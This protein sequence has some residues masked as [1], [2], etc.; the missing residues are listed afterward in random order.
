MD[1][2]TMGTVRE[3]KIRQ[4][5]TLMLGYIHLLDTKGQ[6]ELF[7]LWEEFSDALP[8]FATWV[9]RSLN[10]SLLREALANK[11]KVGIWHGETSA[12]VSGVSLLAP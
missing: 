12:N 1:V 2:E 4:D 11:L 10:V 3:I 7:I 8:P 6:T 5:E 9:E